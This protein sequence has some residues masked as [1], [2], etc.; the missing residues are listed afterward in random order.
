MQ[1][2]ETRYYNPYIQKQG[3]P[4]SLK[5]W[6]PIS[7]SNMIYKISKK[8]LDNRLKIC[9]ENLVNNYQFSGFKNRDIQD[10]GLN[11]HTIISY[12]KQNNISVA[13]ISI[14]NEKAF[15]RVEHN[16]TKK[17]YKI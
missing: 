7:L 4:Y 14:D 11:L 12:A 17:F 5:Y 8:T 3:T 10:N 13:L 9:M 16:F 15:D 1:L 6:R 2:H